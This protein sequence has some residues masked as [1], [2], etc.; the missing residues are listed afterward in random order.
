MKKQLIA[1]LLMTMTSASFAAPLDTTI[2]MLPSTSISFTS[3]N[4]VTEKC[5]IP[6]RLVMGQDDNQNQ[7]DLKEVPERHRKG[8]KFYPV[9][10]F[11]EV[12]DIAY[13]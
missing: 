9:K 5:I 11:Q 13:R 6:A 12:L 1:T 10:T 3:P 4:N 7:K 8:L 2:S